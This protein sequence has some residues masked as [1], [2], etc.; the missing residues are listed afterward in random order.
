MPSSTNLDSFDQPTLLKF[1]YDTEI[2]SG[3]GV[4]PLPFAFRS[5]SPSPSPSPAAAAAATPALGGINRRPP[6]GGPSPDAFSD[7]P[8]RALPLGVLSPLREPID[9]GSFGCTRAAA[10]TP[11]PLPSPFDDSC[12][13]PCEV[14]GPV[15]V[16]EIRDILRLFGGSRRI[17]DRLSIPSKRECIGELDFESHRS[18]REVVFGANSRCRT[19]EGFVGFDSLLRI[20]IPSSVEVIRWTAFHSCRELREVIFEGNSHVRVIHGFMSCRALTRIVIPSSVEM[21]GDS[22]F[23]GCAELKEVIFEANSELLEIAGFAFCPS[24]SRMVLPPSLR[25]ISRAAFHGC[26]G[27]RVLEFPWGSQLRNSTRLQDCHWLMV[28][29]ESELKDSRRGVQLGL[30]LGFHGCGC[31]DYFFW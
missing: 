4:L 3:G 8:S 5:P 30:G 23:H 11:G 28:Y 6:F 18:V 9:R 29:G 13:K 22:A 20:E 12:E 24:L 14:I 25:D 26:A 10:L 21:I 19:I 15:I 17:R 1:V 27:P 16:S 31:G 2:V 7:F